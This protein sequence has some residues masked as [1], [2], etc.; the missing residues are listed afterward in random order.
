[1]N[2]QQFNNLTLMKKTFSEIISFVFHPLFMP[3]YAIFLL[4][5]TDSRIGYLH[6]SLKNYVYGIFIISVI[7][8]PLI[9]VLAFQSLGL[10]SSLMLEKKRER[11]LP[12]FVLTI[13]TLSTYIFLQS[14]GIVPKVVLLFIYSI[15][16][17]AFVTATISW[18][19]KISTHMVGAG[20]VLA[21]ILFVAL[22]Y[23]INL[24]FIFAPLVLIIGLV[25][26][27]RLYL[28]KHSTTEVYIGFLQGFSIT[29]AS[30]FI[31]VYL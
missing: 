20:G 15:S 14:G 3:L 22:V 8:I 23:W 4:F 5:N 29:G 12:L 16:I 28:Q 1:M 18:F 25:A 13:S 24:D 11:V 26:F 10:I 7:I 9:M 2:N 19:W 21:Y 31:L 17:N 6:S 27:A 30:L